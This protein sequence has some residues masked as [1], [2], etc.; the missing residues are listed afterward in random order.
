MHPALPGRVAPGSGRRPHRP[1]RRPSPAQES[2][3]LRTGPPGQ[4]SLAVPCRPADGGGSRREGLGR[5]RG[6]FTSKIH[7]SADGL[8][9]P[10]SLIVTLGQ[11]ADCTQ[12]TAVLEKIRVPRPGAGRPRKKPGSVAADKAY[13]NGL[14]RQYLRRR[15][16]RNAIQHR[17]SGHQQAA[18]LPRRR[19]P[20]RRRPRTRLPRHRHRGRTRHLAP[21]LVS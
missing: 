2:G 16:I 3:G 11:P 7:L 6:G 17:R 12:F 8:C 5:S 9:R 21:H 19:D 4:S 14:C 13:G 18:E 15:G 10:L 1:H 20:L